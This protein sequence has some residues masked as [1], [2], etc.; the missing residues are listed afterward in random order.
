MKNNL[1]GVNNSG[2]IYY[3]D[4]IIFENLL[5]LF[6]STIEMVATS[7]EHFSA[8]CYELFHSGELVL[9]LVLKD[10]GQD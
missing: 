4:G 3:E 2:T 6:A 1:A 5:C 8:N 9:K 10:D 7:S